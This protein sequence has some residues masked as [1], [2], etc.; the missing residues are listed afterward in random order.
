M[1]TIT[2]ISKGSH[3]HEDGT[4]TYV[5]LFKNDTCDLSLSVD[6]ESY[7]VYVV[8]EEYQ[9]T[10]VPKGAGVTNE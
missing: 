10:L 2:C 7:D 9:F 6:K 3:Y 4:V 1:I 5:I 8:G